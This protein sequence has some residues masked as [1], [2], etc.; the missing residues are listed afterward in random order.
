MIAEH[1]KYFKL[2]DRVKMKLTVRLQ[3]TY[4]GLGAE[5]KYVR[6][7]FI[8]SD[9]REWSPIPEQA[10]RFS[11]SEAQVLEVERTVWERLEP[12]VR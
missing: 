10:A 7:F 1:T 3:A 4:R 6:S 8:S 5:V 9:G 12:G 2:L 11:I